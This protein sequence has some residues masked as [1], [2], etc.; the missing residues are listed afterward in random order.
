MFEEERHA[1]SCHADK[2][3][4][5]LGSNQSVTSN[6]RRPL[7]ANWRNATAPSPASGT[8]QPAYKPIAA[9][10]RWCFLL[11]IASFVAEY[12]QVFDTEFL[13]G[14]KFLG[15]VAGLVALRQVNV[16]YARPPRA[17]WWFLAYLCV[18]AARGMSQRDFGYLTPKTMLT[19][20]Q[21]LILLWLTYNLLRFGGMW[22]SVLATF[23]V[24]DFVVALLTFARLTG[25]TGEF[26]MS[27]RES[28]LGLNSN[29]LG[30]L[31]A[32]GVLSGL[33]LALD[34][35]VVPFWRMALIPAILLLAA[36]CV[37]TG[38]RSAMV[39]CAVGIFTYWLG[40][41]GLKGKV[42]GLFIVGIAGTALGGI[43]LHSSIA[44]ERWNEAM[45]GHTTGHV[46][47]LQDCLEMFYEKPL[48][49]WGPTT[50]L[51]E[52]GSRENVQGFLDTH[53][54]IMYML[55][56]TGLLG[57]ACFFGGVWWC[58]VAGW[59]G[60][61]GPA[62]AFPLAFVMGFLAVSLAGTFHREKAYWVIAA[63]AC[64]SG[65]VVADSRMPRNALRP[66]RKANGNGS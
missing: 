49:G 5:K 43:V 35:T 51:T 54:D 8:I 12:V 53:S 11:F 59:K 19:F 57:A 44:R 29:T 24:S 14:T 47:I 52:L 17:F 23:V 42:K 61:H 46:R 4:R 34:K 3:S 62:G 1:G 21:Y 36:K 32:I 27:G 55:T 25:D 45:E 48:A 31:Y 64:A 50:H 22:K 56:G 40:T 30:A 33:A 60:R 37:A 18:Y 13:T 41:K 6:Y 15:I 66:V 63:M 9:P 65:A 16:C 10:I 39:F 7:Q 28:A 26:E 58:I 38:S 20:A 2:S